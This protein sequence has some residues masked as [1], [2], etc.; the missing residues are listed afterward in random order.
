MQKQYLTEVENENILGLFEGQ[1]SMTKP[2][3]CSTMGQS[4]IS[5]I[6]LYTDIQKQAF[7]EFIPF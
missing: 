1:Q 7:M 6:L 3:V 2:I 5:I 4:G